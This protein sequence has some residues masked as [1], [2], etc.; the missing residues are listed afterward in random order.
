MQC[1]ISAS[2][3]QQKAVYPHHCERWLPTTKTSSKA[4]LIW[5][6]WYFDGILLAFSQEVVLSEQFPKVV[7]LLG[8]E[9]IRC[10]ERM[11]LD[12]AWRHGSESA[13]IP[14]LCPARVQSV[15]LLVVLVVGIRELW[16]GTSVFLAQL[17]LKPRAW[18]WLLRA[19]GNLRLGPEPPQAPYEGSDWP[20]SWGFWPGLWLTSAKS[21]R[22]SM[23]LGEV[24]EGIKE[25]WVNEELEEN[26][27][28]SPKILQISSSSALL[29]KNA[30]ISGHTGA[31]ATRNIPAGR[32]S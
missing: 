9:G 20:K 1:L 25:S 2:L 10:S 30:N 29:Q 26:D 16:S 17:G 15:G 5:S 18:A 3:H 6:G 28:L 7:R 24:I 22:P 13:G 12:S 23:K 14:R 21:W 32:S 31:I 4:S 11:G 19:Q 27:S 8:D